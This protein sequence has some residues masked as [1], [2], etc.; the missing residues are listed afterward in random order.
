MGSKEDEASFQGEVA[1]LRKILGVEAGCVRTTE[2]EAAIVAK[3]AVGTAECGGMM[4]DLDS[5]A[6]QIVEPSC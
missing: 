5:M 6:H 4:G 2:G 1:C 3:F